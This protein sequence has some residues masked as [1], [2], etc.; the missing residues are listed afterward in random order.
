MKLHGYFRSSASYRVR[1]ALALKG[2]KAGQAFY[3]LRK[4][5]Q[6][7]DDFLILNPQGLV[8]A[9]ET[10]SGDVLTQSLAMLEWLEETHPNPPMLP[11]DPIAR[12]KVRAFA[13][14]IA[15]EIHPVQNLLVLNH[16]RA[17]GHGDAEVNEWA[18]RTNYEGL[19]ACEKLLAREKGPFCFGAAPTLA[20]ICLIPQMGNARRFGA[21]VSGFKRL[22]EAEAA[23][24]N[25]TAFAEAAP[26]KQPDAE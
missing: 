19:A 21:D 16:I 18:R 22:L 23:C 20:D 6:R 5:E 13:M 10:D 8:P 7:S 9:L 14:V 26:E 17:L 12:A 1:I 24:K 2:L 25:V 11:K 3:H 15:C 4:G